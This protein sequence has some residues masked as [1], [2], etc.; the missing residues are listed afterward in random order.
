MRLSSASWLARRA[1]VKEAGWET[2]N[3][4]YKDLGVGVSQRRESSHA[5]EG[6]GGEE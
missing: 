5:G 2:L 6:V 1:R 3:S 4:C